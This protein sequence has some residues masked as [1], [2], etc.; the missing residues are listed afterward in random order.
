M[1]S[2]PPC[3]TSPP[4][5]RAS[6]AA[7]VT[8]TASP[9][10]FEPSAEADDEAGP[11]KPVPP[12]AKA[13]GAVSGTSTVSAMWSLW[14]PKRPGASYKF[15]A[16]SPSDHSNSPAIYK[17]RSVGHRCDNDSSG[18]GRSNW[19]DRGPVVGCRATQSWPGAN[20]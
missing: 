12:P 8:I 4:N 16:G 5:T 19:F 1:I 17:S 9:S 18:R 13:L 2:M 10:G 20:N 15:M 6:P 14:A 3:V 11:Q 7:G